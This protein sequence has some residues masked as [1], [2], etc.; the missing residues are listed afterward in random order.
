MGKKQFSRLL[1]NKI[2]ILDG[3]TGTELQKRGM[4]G[5]ACPEEWAANNPDVIIDIQKE[6]IMAGS[7][8][9]YSCSFGANRIKLS[10]YG[11]QDKVVELNK[12]LAG[13]SKEAVEAAG[14]NCLVA[15]DLAPTGSFMEPMGDM[16]FE[17]SV[18][19]YKEQIE[20]LLKGGVDLFV[21]ETMMDIQEARAALIAVKESCDLPVMVSMSFECNH[22]TLMGTDAITA[23]ITL[24]SLG[25][26]VVG[27][28]CSTGPLEMIEIIKEMKPYARVPLLAKPNAGVPRVVDGE[29]RFE[30][31]TDEFASFASGFAEAGVRLLGGCCGTSPQYIEKLSKRISDIEIDNNINEDEKLEASSL[32]GKRGL[33]S[34]SSSRSTI[35]LDDADSP[36]TMGGSINA[37][38]NPSFREQLIKGQ[39]EDV[40]DLAMDDLADGAKILNIN[41]AGDG[42]DEEKV[43][44]DIV[45]QLS[46]TAPA[47]IS[48]ESISVEVLEAALRAFPGRAL[49]NISSSAA[50]ALNKYE[51]IQ[52]IAEKYGALFLTEGISGDDVLKSAVEYNGKML[53]VILHL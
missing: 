46:G 30:M 10:N 14:G 8:I 11:L 49:I 3:A 50:T 5:G 43:I 31:G 45:V 37:E 1:E 35:H 21:I 2:V 47:V 20:G 29:T 42:I 12:R 24:Q 9:I 41:I 27:C 28:N 40:I 17:E 33:Y 32:A 23:L 36:A 4:P 39:T 19:V 7:E 22:R 6:Y 16:T 26:D 13:L 34:L 44:K 53:D 51:D 18:N 15:G 25:A 48:V 38:A 52:K